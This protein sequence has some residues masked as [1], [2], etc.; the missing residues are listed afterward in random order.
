[1][2]ADLLMQEV[3][4]RLGR[5]EIK[6]D[7]VDERM[8]I[9]E[10]TQER[11][12]NTVELHEKRSTTLEKTHELCKLTCDQQLDELTKLVVAISQTM[13]TIKKVFLWMG[14]SVAFISGMTQIINFVMEMRK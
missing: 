3:L 5:I 7:K 9:M 10:R 8:D 1:M 2:T 6:I 11:L 13:V 4:Q 12:T 14:G